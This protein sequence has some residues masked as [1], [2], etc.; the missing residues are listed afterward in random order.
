[1]RRDRLISASPLL[2]FLQAIRKQLRRSDTVVCSEGTI[3]RGVDL[4]DRLDA[5]TV[6]ELITPSGKCRRSRL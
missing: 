2:F 6:L 5:R 1:M 3:Y 4:I